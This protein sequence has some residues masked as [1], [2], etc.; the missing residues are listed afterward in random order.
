MERKNKN[1]RADI[2]SAT[3]IG[4]IILI[5]GFVVLLIFFYGLNLNERADIETCHQSVVFRATLPSFGGV[6]D[7]IPLKCQTNKICITSK[8]IGG[9]CAEFKNVKGTTTIKVKN[10]DDIEK[11][12]AEKIIEC[13]GMMGEGKL[14]VFTEQLATSY[15]IGTIGSSCVICDRIAF[16]KSS[17]KLSGINLDNV[18]V[19]DYM[20]NHKIPNKNVSYYVYFAGKGGTASVLPDK[21]EVAD[22]NVNDQGIGEI[23]NK[24]TI[25]L[26]DAPEKSDVNE[27][28]VMFMQVSGPTHTGVLRNT[29]LTALGAAGGGYIVSP[30]IGGKIIG[31]A[32]KSPYFWVLAVLGVGIQQYNVARN[33]AITAG[34]CGDLTVGEQAR[35]GCSA[36]RVV[37]YNVDEISQFCSIIESIP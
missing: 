14:S 28:A 17:L 21:I 29:V 27:F 31:A 25:D 12:I 1:K 19:M 32:M 2:T 10:E 16:D 26:Q 9:E 6:K 4:I 33:K 5:I 35:E 7:Y 8:T 30:K 15:G 20:M 23:G 3:L 13:W 34:Y 37:N 18:D 22:I 36:V 24:E 11:I